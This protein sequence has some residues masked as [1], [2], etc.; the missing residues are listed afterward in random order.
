[1]GAL[2]VGH[3]TLYG[4]GTHQRASLTSERLLPP[5]CGSHW[6]F[7]IPSVCSSGIQCTPFP[8]RIPHTSE[9]LR[10]RV[11]SSHTCTPQV[12]GMDVLAVKHAVAFAK[13]YALANGPIVMEMDTYRWV[14]GWMRTCMCN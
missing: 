2:A 4:M 13:D 8:H 11:T 7:P 1:M 14:G 6:H 12:D 3:P 9:C 10:Q 5:S